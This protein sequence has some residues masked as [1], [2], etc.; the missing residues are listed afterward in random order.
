MSAESMRPTLLLEA[1][2]IREEMA[3]G[4]E[5]QSDLEAELIQRVLGGERSVPRTCAPL[6]TC[7]IHG[8]SS[9]PEK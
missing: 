3:A 9:Y 8:D 5:A 2:R 1:P 6:R 7:S 4:A